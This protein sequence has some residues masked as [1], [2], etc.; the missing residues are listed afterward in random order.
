MV[1]EGSEGQVLGAVVRILTESGFTLPE[2]GQGAANL[3]AVFEKL[4]PADLATVLRCHVA[5]FTALGGVPQEIRLDTSDIAPRQTATAQVGLTLDARVPVAPAFDIPD[6][7]SYGLG[8][9]VVLDCNWLQIYENVM[10]PFHVAVLH[11]TF[12]GGQFSAAMSARILL[13]T[14]SAE[15]ASPPSAL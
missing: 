10:D 13:L 12:S 4:R 14:A 3:L 5:A 8:G 15:T 11:S 7:T 6:G 1:D 2:E 9:G